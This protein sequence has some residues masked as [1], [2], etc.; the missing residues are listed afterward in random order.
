VT[1]DGFST[2]GVVSEAGGSHVRPPWPDGVVYHGSRL[3]LVL[4][5][6]VTITGL[7]PPM[8]ESTLGRFEEGMVLSEPVI[9]Q[10]PFTIPKSTAELQRERADAAAGVPP[11]FNYRPEAGDTMAVRLGRFFARLDSVAAGADSVAFGGISETLRADLLEASIVISPG[12]ALLLTDEGTRRLLS[13]TSVSGVRRYAEMGVVDATESS[14]LT[15][16]RVLIQDPGEDSR[17]SEARENILVGGDLQARILSDLPA[18]SPEV[19]ELLRL[20]I[21]S[22]TVYSLEFDAE[23]TAGDREQVRQAVPESIGN[24]VQQEAIVRANEPIT[25]LDLARLSAYEAELRRLQL[26]EESGLQFGLLLGAFLLNFSLVAVFGAL[27]FF[28]RPAIYGSLRWLVLQSALVVIYFIVARVIASNG[29]APEALPITFV[30][31]ALAILWDSRVAL[32][33]GLVLA[34]LTVAQPA[35]ADTDVLFPLMVGGAA[36]AMCVRVVR[37]RAQ[38]W[39]FVAIITGAYAIT[40]LALSLVGERSAA[41][42]AVSMTWA[43]SNAALSAIIAMGFV[44]VFEWFTGITTDQT[45]LEWAD[46]NAPLLRR[47]SLEA[48]GTYAHTINVANLA[49]LAANAVGAHGL[50]CRVG[51]YYHDVGKVLKPHYFVENQ[52]EGRNPHDKLKPDTSSAILIEHVVEGLRLGKEA[53]LPEVIQRFITE[54]HG[55]Q[56]IAYFYSRAKEQLG[57]ENVDEADYRYPGPKPQSKETAIAMMA[58]S[59]ESATRVLQEPTPERVRDLVDGIIGSKQQDGQLDQ[60][61]LTMREITTLKD[62]FVKVLSGIYHHRIDYP[63]TKHLT[64]APDE[65]RDEA[66]AGESGIEA[67]RVPVGSDVPEDAGGSDE[68][69]A[70]GTSEQMELGDVTRS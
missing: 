54:H 46:P 65:A 14:E 69:G 15:V 60:A 34:G 29:L 66:Q 64:D 58:D 37:R 4:A 6:A 32:V 25:D 59:I 9:A 30:V 33:M 26:L 1:R 20:I 49:E 52:V 5:V 61:P 68:E 21:I 12:Q 41:D 28:L 40:L 47:L 2:Y 42:F 17:R 63:T 51:L 13:T 56:L 31:L 22:H 55:T 10:V 45:L 8:G 67:Q 7:F 11:T 27:I 23:V 35:F 48:P 38:T 19:S 39:V 3:L 44:P 57:E 50:L 24:V 62:T 70:G 36:A 18:T 43:G 53:G 16:D